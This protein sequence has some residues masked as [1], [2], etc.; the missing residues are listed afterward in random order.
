MPALES[1]F[2]LRR[3]HVVKLGDVQ[4]DGERI[5]IERS[6]SASSGRLRRP[7]GFHLCPDAPEAPSGPFIFF[8]KL[9]LCIGLDLRLYLDVYGDRLNLGRIGHNSRFCTL[10]ASFGLVLTFLRC[11]P[12]LDGQCDSGIVGIRAWQRGRDR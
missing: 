8:I 1:L 6:L 11:N 5:R 7:L 12:L 4:R 10:H 3:V 2:L 9:S